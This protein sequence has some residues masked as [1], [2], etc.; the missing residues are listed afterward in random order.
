MLMADF[1]A[2][3]SASD[4]HV[5]PY[6]SGKEAMNEAPPAPEI[7]QGKGYKMVQ[8]THCHVLAPEGRFLPAMPHM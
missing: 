3:W 6:N 7:E 8:I 5:F 4:R 1:S 2:T